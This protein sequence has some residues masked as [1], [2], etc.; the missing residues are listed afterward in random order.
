MKKNN[1]NNSNKINNSKIW[2]GRFSSSSNQLM[3][4][5]NS[6]IQFDQ[7]LYIEDIDGSIVFTQKCYLIKKLLLKKNFNQL[8]SGLNQI[9]K[10][11]FNNEFV[12]SIEL[13]DIHMNIETRLIEIIGE[14]GKKLHTARSR[15]DQVAN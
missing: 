1:S 7:K 8:K 4:E 6:S 10:E 13:E 2:G 15:N 5:F 3:E 12:F 11:I 9:K 14:P